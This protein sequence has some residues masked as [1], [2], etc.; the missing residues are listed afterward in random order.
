MFWF[1]KKIAFSHMPKEFWPIMHKAFP[2]GEKQLD[3]EANILF[4]KYPNLFTLK[5]AVDL[6]VWTKSTILINNNLSFDDVSRAINRHEENRLTEE[7]S[8]QIYT[9][10]L[11]QHLI[12]KQKSSC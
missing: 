5:S 12:N 8:N 2:L 10:I 11:K 9:E 6:I 4:N 1:K 3:E 7:Q